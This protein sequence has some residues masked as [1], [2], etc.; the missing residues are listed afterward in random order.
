MTGK[1]KRFTVR[2]SSR[3]KNRNSFLD[4]QNVQIKNNFLCCELARFINLYLRNAYLSFD[5][6]EHIAFEFSRWELLNYDVHV[7]S[8]FSIYHNPL[9]HFSPMFHFNTPWKCQKTKS[10]LAFSRHYTKIKFSI[11]D[12]FSKCDQILFLDEIQDQKLH[13]LCSEKHKNGKLGQRYGYW[14]KQCCCVNVLV[15]TFINF[16]SFLCISHVDKC[17]KSEPVLYSNH[18]NT[19]E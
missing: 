4:W 2:L 10:F 7:F 19:S 15:V 12:F 5:W 11:K 9:T 1:V 6:K 18:M 17:T 8:M 13:F 16:V 3:F 14:Q